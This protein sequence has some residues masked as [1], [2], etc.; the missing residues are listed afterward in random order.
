[1]NTWK[2]I[3]ATVVIFVAG[4]I[5]GGLVVG[6]SDQSRAL[7]K[8]SKSPDVVSASNTNHEIRVPAPMFGPLRK[9]FI[10]RLQKELKINVTQREHI[11]KIICEGQ[12]QL[13]NV[14]WEVEPDI[15]DILNETKNKIRAELTEAQQAQFEELLKSRSHNPAKPATNAPPVLTN[16]TPAKS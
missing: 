3:L 2:I 4:A 12:E 16:S 14:W 9:D 13:R 5:T 6:F 7:H 1:V 8:G 10:D 11:E 15:H